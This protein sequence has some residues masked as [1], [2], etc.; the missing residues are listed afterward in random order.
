M[1]SASG[2]ALNSRVRYPIGLS[3]LRGP[4]GLIAAPEGHL[5]ACP[6]AGDT[7]TRSCVISSI[8]QVD[9]PS[10]KVSPT[11]LSNTISSSSSPTRAVPGPPPIRNTPK[12]PRSGIVP[13]LTTATRR[14]PSLAVQ[15]LARPVPREP[16]PELGELVRGVPA[17][18]HVEHAVEDLA[19]ESGKR[20]G[21]ANGVEQLRHVPVVHGDHR[22]H[23]LRQHVEWTAR[24]PDR[25]HL[26]AAHR[27]CGG[28]RRQQIRAEFRKDDALADGAHVM[29]APSDSL[30]PA[31]DR[32]RRFDLHDEVDRAHVDAELEGRGRNEC[33]QPPFLERLLDLEALGMGNRSVVRARQ[34]LARQLVQRARQPLG[35]PAV[36]DE[37]QRGA[38]AP[39]ELEQPGMNGGP[40]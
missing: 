32:R 7:S 14:A 10:T 11:L 9:A 36:V 30:Q 35:Q 18:E 19:V 31:G 4:P 12:S 40:D 15:P 29:T 20:G 16:R 25:L 21:A 2:A 28:G 37:D 38:A 24:I 27:A 33:R 23:L 6:G 17:R 13:P 1:A 34:H 26:A 8:R 5:A 22:R 39:N 3:E